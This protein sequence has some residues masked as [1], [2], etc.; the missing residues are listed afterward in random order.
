MPCNI[1]GMI[2][3]GRR[4]PSWLLL[5]AALCAASSAGCGAGG[6]DARAARE[7]AA[8]P[9][10]KL[11]AEVE[12]VAGEGRLTDFVRA[13]MAEEA[14][15]VVPAE[16]VTKLLSESVKGDGGLPAERA[17]GVRTKLFA[18]VLA[19]LRDAQVRSRYRESSD[20]TAALTALFRKEFRPILREA[21]RLGPEGSGQTVEGEFGT[22]GRERLQTFFGVCLFN[23]VN[24]AGQ[25]LAQ[26]LFAEM[27]ELAGA[28]N[29]KQLDSYK[30]LAHGGAGL[31]PRAGAGLLGGLVALLRNGSKAAGG[32]DAFAFT[33]SGERVEAA[34]LGDFFYDRMLA[35][36]GDNADA[37]QGS[38][39]AISKSGAG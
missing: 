13:A 26:F 32:A 35:Q 8:G 38:H 34:R 36:M 28:V 23:P 19:G 2:F 5:F 17:A 22:E 24:P 3:K 30:D 33:V 11:M 20:F 12:R 31:A 15:G 9:P 16:G 10:E 4:A 14:R 1:K 7:L 39:A 27:N 25:S 18:A 37:F 21:T 6:G 29:R